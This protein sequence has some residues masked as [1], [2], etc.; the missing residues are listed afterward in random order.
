MPAPT[1]VQRKSLLTAALAAGKLVQHV[2]VK[3]IELAPG[4]AVGLHRHPCP[5]MGYVAA[6]TI[7][8]QIRGQ[9]AQYLRAGD[10]FFEP[11][12]VEIAHFDNASADEPAT[13][14]A[15]YLLGADE[16][17]LIEMLPMAER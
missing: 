16:T 9:P 11:E 4:Q 2:E 3:Q 6:G 14:I 5:V 7:Q 12:H 1:V 15:F 13:F 17:E 10:G 8:F